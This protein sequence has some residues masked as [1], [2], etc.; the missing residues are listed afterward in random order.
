MNAQ[1]KPIAQHIHAGYLG[2]GN[3]AGILGVSPYKTPLQEY[4]AILGDDEAATPEREVFFARR[5]ALEPFALA[6]F[7]QEVPGRD[8][9]RAN[10]RYTDSEHAFIRAEIDAETDAGENIE[11]KTVHPMAAKDW[12]NAGGDDIPVYVTAQC[13]H[14]LMVTGRTVCF[15]IAMIGFDDF[16]VYRIERDDEIIAGM[17]AKEVA[18][19][20]DHVETHT[21]PEP[22]NADDVLRMFD[23]DSGASVEADAVMLE[24]FNRLRELR[25]AIKTES[26]EADALEEKIKLHLRD[27]AALTLDG[28]PI[29]TWKTQS[30]RRFN[31][32]AFS[33]AEPELFAQFKTASN[34]RVFRIK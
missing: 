29:A 15:P 23:H 25:A 34:S 21:P 7:K 22:A 4:H 32:K 8:V 1:L 28:K 24:T 11:I 9:A 20:R 5:K 16:R 6:L 26:A 3:V 17:R 10:E 14:G 33:A 30:S 27:A 12:G 13:M 19:W 31:Q 2:G 18:F